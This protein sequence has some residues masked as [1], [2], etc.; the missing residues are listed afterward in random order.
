MAFL[1]QL[2]LPRSPA[3]QPID[4]A[5]FQQVR[6]ELTSKFGGVTVYD[7]AP[8]EGLWKSGSQ[9]WVRDQIV[10]FEVMTK[11]LNRRWWRTYRRELELRLRQKEL[12]VRSHR[13]K[14]L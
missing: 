1:V 7:R 8:A 14:R 12:V 10:L 6:A 3:G 13:I 9:E 4:A 2:L 5:T 11:K